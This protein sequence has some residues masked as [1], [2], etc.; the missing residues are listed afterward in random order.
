MAISA[1]PKSAKLSIWL[2]AILLEETEITTR[3]HW[4]LL[5]GTSASQFLYA[6]KHTM[7]LT[8]KET[9]TTPILRASQFVRKCLGHPHTHKSTTQ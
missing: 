7:L 9:S 6:F 8:N 3:L 2:A 1:Q 4:H 5:R